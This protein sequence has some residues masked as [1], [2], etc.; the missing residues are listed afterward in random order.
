MAGELVR[1]VSNGLQPAQQGTLSGSAA[2]S[3]Q[4]LAKSVQ[5]L[6][7]TGSD[8]CAIP[9]ALA[10]QFILRP[11]GIGTQAQGIGGGQRLLP[12]RGLTV[13]FTV[14][15]STGQARTVSQAVIVY[16]GGG[17]TKLLGMH[18]LTVNDATITW[19]PKS[20]S[21]KLSAP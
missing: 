9:E 20:G 13:T 7:D 10:N 12:K 21:G 3:G 17:G 16:I 19:S 1:H 8:V 18:E 4:P 14:E 15:D 5:W 6:V 2:D 11:A